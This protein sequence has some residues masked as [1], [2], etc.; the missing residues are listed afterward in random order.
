MRVHNYT[1]A[2]QSGKVQFMSNNTS[3][4][5][6]Y[7]ILGKY[8]SKLRHNISSSVTAAKNIEKEMYVSHLPQADHKVGKHF[9][10]CPLWCEMIDL[11]TTQIIIRFGLYTTNNLLCTINGHEEVN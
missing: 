5:L 11:K 10:N 9:L 2:S 1:L 8:F 6:E 3:Y 7:L 4:L